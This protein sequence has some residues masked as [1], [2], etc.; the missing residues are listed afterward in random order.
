MAAGP[1]GGRQTITDA[2]G[3]FQGEAVSK[4]DEG[5][6]LARVVPMLCFSR[7]VSHSES[8][9]PS[10]ARVVRKERKMSFAQTCVKIYYAKSTEGR[11]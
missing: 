6:R 10:K 1:G 4:V 11:T 2:S 5:R 8:S 9:N 3:A 7:A